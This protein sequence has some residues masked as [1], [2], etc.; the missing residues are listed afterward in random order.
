MAF[1]TLDQ[2]RTTGLNDE[3]GLDVDGDNTWGT[4]TQR[5]T[6]IQRAIA[7]LWPRMARLTRE[8]VLTV[9]DTQ[10]YTLTGLQDVERI[11]IMSIAAPTVIAGHIKTFQMYVDEAASP[12]TLRLTI[13]NPQ[14]GQTLRVIGYKPYIIPAAGGS[15]CDIPNG[16]EWIVYAGARVEAYRRMISKMANFERFQNENR[17]NSLTPA[18]LVELLRQARTDFESGVRDNSRN[19]TGAKRAILTLG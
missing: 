5:N 15:S 14:A 12:V 8:T 9:L 19:L 17:Q 11:E 2:L 1:L 13:P 18:D 6:F 7:R 10:D 3:L 4:T 16:L